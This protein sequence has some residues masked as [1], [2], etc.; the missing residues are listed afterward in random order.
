MTLTKVL[1]YVVL[2]IVGIIIY[3]L[4]ESKPKPTAQCFL[5]LIG[6]GWLIG[7]AFGFYAW[8]AA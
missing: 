3:H 5:W 4:A 6:T 8:H 1:A 2:G 7:L